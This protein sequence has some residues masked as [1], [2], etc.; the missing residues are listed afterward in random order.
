MTLAVVIFLAMAA[1][2]HRFEMQMRKFVDAIAG[3]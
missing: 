3:G 1:E 2:D